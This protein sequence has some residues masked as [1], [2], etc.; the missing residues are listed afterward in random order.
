[1]HTTRQTQA[2]VTELLY[3]IDVDTLHREDAPTLGLNDIGRVD[4]QHGTAACSATPTPKTPPRAA[5]S[6]S[7]RTPT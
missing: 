4:A 6:S 7:T 2:Y 5:S 1:M 3:R